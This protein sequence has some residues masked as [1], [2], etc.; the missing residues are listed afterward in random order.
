VSESLELELQ[1][2][3]RHRVGVGNQAQPTGRA[4]NAL[5]C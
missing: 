4:A 3:V 5:N 1:V 2:V